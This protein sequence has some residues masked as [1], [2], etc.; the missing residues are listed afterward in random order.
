MPVQNLAGQ[1]LMETVEFVSIS[2]LNQNHN[3]SIVIP[4]MKGNIDGGG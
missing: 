2:P 4:L 1:T 3:L